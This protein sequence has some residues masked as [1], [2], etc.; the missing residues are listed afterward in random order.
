MTLIDAPPATGTRP[1]Q[2]SGMHTPHTTTSA[3]LKMLPVCS[4]TQQPQRK[5]QK[6]FKN[7]C[8]NG[9][10]SSMSGV[11]DHDTHWF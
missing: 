5:A 10:V 7:S 3:Q 9:C 11:I 4:G 6:H 8:S 1:C 2:V